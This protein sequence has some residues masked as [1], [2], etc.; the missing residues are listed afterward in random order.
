[1]SA[2]PNLPSDSSMPQRGQRKPLLFVLLVLVLLFVITYASRLTEY[3]QLLSQD[4]SMQGQIDDAEARG[5]QLVKDLEYVKSRAYTE[6]MAI[7]ELGMG[8]KDDQVLT[9]IDAPA[10]VEVE[11]GQGAAIDAA[12]GTAGDAAVVLAQDGSATDA[13]SPVWRQWLSVFRPQSE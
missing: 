13:Q 7:T 8:Q 6:K 2:Q 1:M 10:L 12:A 3:R 9:V 5:R 11:Q 4:A